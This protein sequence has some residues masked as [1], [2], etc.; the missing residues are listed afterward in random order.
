VLRV[1]TALGLSKSDAEVYTLIATKGPIEAREMVATLCMERKRFYTT[2]KKLANSGLIR[3]TSKPSA[4]LTA[5][6]F[7]EVLDSCLSSKRKSPRI[8]SRTLLQHS[9]C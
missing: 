3:I 7:E 5:V 8:W 6:D 4:Y 2:I 1:L 9:M